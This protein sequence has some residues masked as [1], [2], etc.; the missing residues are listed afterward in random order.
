[1]RNLLILIA[2]YGS[3]L[4]FL[5]LELVCFFLIINFNKSQG[6]IFLHSANLLSGKVNQQTQKISDF[7]RLEAENDSLLTENARLLETI[8]NFRIHDQENNFEA[9]E[10]KDSLAIY[11]FIPARIC[12]KTTHLRNNYITLCSGKNDS[13]IEGMGVISNTGIV[14]IVNNVTDNYAQAITILHSQSRISAALKS[15]QYHGTLIWEGSEANKL[16]LITLPKYAEISVGDTIVTSGYSTVFPAG[17]P[18][19]KVLNYSIDGGGDNYKVDVELF[20]NLNK[21][22]YVYVIN[23]PE[24]EEKEQVEISDGN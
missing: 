19:G 13:I 2:K 22:S 8:I 4:L 24:K 5:F 20:N 21:L 14:G 18:V 11:K 16:S 9:F 7:L 17:V 23:F 12:N 15:S 1:M 6:E 10:N 3:T